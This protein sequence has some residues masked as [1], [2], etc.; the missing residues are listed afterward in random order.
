MVVARDSRQRCKTVGTLLPFGFARLLIGRGPIEYFQTGSR[1][2]TGNLSKNRGWSSS[3]R[4]GR[5]GICC[6]LIR[7]IET[8]LDA[9]ADSQGRSECKGRE[10]IEW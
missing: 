1:S 9:S 10:E 2:S 5:V 3:L 6:N 8:V 7:I 4:E